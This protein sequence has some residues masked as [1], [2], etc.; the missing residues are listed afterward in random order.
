MA[1]GSQPPRHNEPGPGRRIVEGLQALF[2]T[3]TPTRDPQAVLELHWVAS[4]GLQPHVHL[5][6]VLLRKRQGFE[7]HGLCKVESAAV[8]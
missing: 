8:G 5:N 3:R 7:K 1:S 6:V 2:C 4:A